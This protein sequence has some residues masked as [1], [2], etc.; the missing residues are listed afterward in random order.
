MHLARARDGSE[1]ILPAALNNLGVAQWRQDR[2]NEAYRTFLQ[3]LEADPRFL[4]ARLNLAMLAAGPLQDQRTALNVITAVP[5]ETWE[6]TDYA[7][8]VEPAFDQD[9]RQDTMAYVRVE[10]DLQPYPEDPLKKPGP[11]DP[12]SFEVASNRPPQQPP[13]RAQ[14]NESDQSAP[15]PA[16]RGPYPYKNIREA[17]SAI[18]GH[19]RQPRSVLPFPPEHVATLDRRRA[20]GLLRQAMTQRL[21]EPSSPG[22]QEL[23]WQAIEADPTFVQAYYN[24][25]MEYWRQ[26][27]NEEAI[28]TMDVAVSKDPSLISGRLQL[29]DWLFQEGYA[30]EAAE[31]ILATLEQDPNH[32][33]ALFL[34]AQ[35][36]YGDPRAKELTRECLERA[37]AGFLPPSLKTTAERLLL[38]LQE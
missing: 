17:L 11:E 33:N 35:V 14:A 38:D 34:A 9:M 29:A 20:Q 24:L 28:Q 25:A 12:E 16:V 37:M 10:R 31:H 26:G 8:L 1:E 32:P 27:R 30:A 5:W 13:Q 7:R 19:D 6:T 23:Y 4:P 18:K 21:S 15:E 2:Q 36:M 22:I 3:A